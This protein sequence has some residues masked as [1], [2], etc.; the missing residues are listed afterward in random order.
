L[1]L[2]RIHLNLRSK[3]AR[4]DLANSYELHST[5]CRAFSI[6]GEKCPEGA[7]L[8]RLEPEEE[9]PGQA[10]V[11][12]QSRSL[13]EWSRIGQ[14]GWFARPAEPSIDLEERL[15]LASL[16]VGQR[17]RYRL[18]ANP[19]T[20]KNGSRQGLLRLADQESW[21]ERRGRELDG[22]ELPKLRSF[23]LEDEVPAGIDVKISQAQI[24]KGKQRTGNEISVFSVLYDGY[25]SVRDPDQFRLALRHGIGHG[26]AFGLGLFSVVPVP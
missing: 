9:V 18:R 17:F 4:R 8:W 19:C 23:S 1:F 5:L 20:T 15:K 22:F 12:V 25:L 13:P 6:P 14:D 3:E 10:R 11:L 26:K 24:M 21:I 2:T 7:F 16:S